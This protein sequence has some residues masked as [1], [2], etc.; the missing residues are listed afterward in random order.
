MVTRKKYTAAMIAKALIG[1]L[2]AF[3]TWGGTALAD[4]KI[5]PV[6]WFGLTGVAVVGL[7][8]FAVKNA[9]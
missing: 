9:K 4:G 5:E 6:E 2:T 3:G 1:A 8:V 7:T